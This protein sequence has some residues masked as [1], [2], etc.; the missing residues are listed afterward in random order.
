MSEGES[1]QG[2]SECTS[3]EVTPPQRKRAPPFPKAEYI[4][5]VEFLERRK[6]GVAEKGSI[7][8]QKASVLQDLVRE[9]EANF[10][11]VHNERQIKKRYSDLKE[12]EKETYESIRSKIARDKELEQ[13]RF[14]ASETT[15]DI[16]SQLNV[17]QST[18][19]Q[20]DMAEEMITLTFEPIPTERLTENS[21]KQIMPVNMD[22][23]F[24][25]ME[26]RLVQHLHHFHIML[27]QKIY[28]L[29]GKIDE[30]LCQLEKEV[31]DLKKKLFL[32]IIELWWKCNIFWG[33]CNQNN[34]ISN[35]V[36]FVL[37]TV[38]NDLRASLVKK[39]YCNNYIY[40][41]N[42]IIYLGIPVEGVVKS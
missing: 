25:E 22:E 31:A 24:S 11:I 15:H 18:D 35:K 12:R 8:T 41:K 5:M 17:T 27:S 30:R 28:D 39:N 16:P 7:N 2:Q 40:K 13:C 29:E 37:H 33:K 9:L 34:D 3:S 6:Y 20:V 36:N 19:T 38:Y 26:N 10:G 32:W 4:F 21:I 42:H 1:E 23:K 14:P